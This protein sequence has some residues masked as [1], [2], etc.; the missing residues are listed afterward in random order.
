[1][2]VSFS[3]LPLLTLVKGFGPY[4]IRHTTS[5][6]MYS[7]TMNSNVDIPKVFFVLGGP[8]AGKGTQCGK[9]SDEYDILHLSAGE[10]LREER[11]SGS[12]KGEVIEA[13]IREGKIV[14]SHITVDLIE[15]AIVASKAN[16]ILGDFIFIYELLMP[17][18]IVF[19]TLLFCHFF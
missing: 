15:K 10:L 3:L 18:C 16:R 11:A 9:L 7:M 6:Y 1:M 14:P 17:S 12:S 5:R 13:L 4:K 19:I 8:G 2:K